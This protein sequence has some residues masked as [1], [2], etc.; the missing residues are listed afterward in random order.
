MTGDIVAPSAEVAQAIA[1]TID[2]IIETVNDAANKHSGEFGDDNFALSVLVNA[3]AKL[4]LTNAAATCAVR[5][6]A[7]EATVRLVAK[8]KATPVLIALPSVLMNYIDANAASIAET[9][10]LLS[11]TNEAGAKGSVQ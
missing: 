7:N 6:Q 5:E 11:K 1:D 9:A 10:D 3:L 2:S 4:I 8:A